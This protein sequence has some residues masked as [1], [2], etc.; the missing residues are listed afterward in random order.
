MK[1]KTTV[2]AC[3]LWTLFAA[4]HLAGAGVWQNIN[5]GDWSDPANWTG[6]VPNGPGDV[7]TFGQAYP[8]RS[9]WITFDGEVRVGTIESLN[10]NVLSLGG[11]GSL[12]MDAADNGQ[13]ELRLHPDAN[14]IRIYN[15][16]AVA[17]GDDLLAD[18][19][20]GAALQLS[21][22]FDGG[23]AAV[24]K[25]GPGRLILTESASTWTGPLDV[26]GGTVEVYDA[27]SL[28]S[29]T[30]ATR[31]AAGG[32][33]AIARNVG[34]GAEPIVLD[35]GTLAGPA[36]G[37]ATLTGPVELR[38]TG[39]LRSEGNGRLRVN[40]PIHG[41][42]ELTVAGNRV[43]FNAANTYTGDVRVTGGELLV[44]HAEALGNPGG[45]TTIEADGTLRLGV[46]DIPDEPIVLAGG[47]LEGPTGGTATFGGTLSGTGTS[48][49]G[50]G[51]IRL[52]GEN[53]FSGTM[54]LTSGA[55]LIAD[56]ES[57]LGPA[58]ANM[59]IHS[60]AELLVSGGLEFRGG[61][62][63]LSGG[64]MEQAPGDTHGVTVYNAIELA[65][66]TRSRFRCD[67]N[68]RFYLRGP[69]TGSGDVSFAGSRQWGDSFSLHGENTYTGK[70]YLDAESTVVNVYHPSGLGSPKTGTVVEAG[71]L[72]FEVSSSEP[73]EVLSGGAL[74]L[75]P[76]DESYLGTCLLRGGSLVG[77]YD[78]S[79]RRTVLES[80]LIIDRGTVGGSSY[81]PLM[82]LKNG[83]TGKRTL[84]TRR[85]TDAIIEGTVDHFGDFRASGEVELTGRV[86]H[87][88][89]L[90]VGDPYEQFRKGKVTLAAGAAQ[91][92]GTTF[93]RT[94]GLVFE[95]DN[96]I[97]TLVLDGR[98]DY[99]LWTPSTSVRLGS[100]L[101]IEGEFRFFSGGFSGNLDGV[102]EI[103]KTTRAYGGLSHLGEGFDGPIIVYGGQLG[104]GDE[105]GLGSSVGTTTVAASENAALCIGYYARVIEDVYLNNATGIE[106]EG[107]LYGRYDPW[108]MGELG[109]N[110]FL[111]DRG[112]CIGGNLVLSAAIHGGALTKVDNSE[113][114]IT[115]GA[116]TYTGPTTVNQ[117]ELILSGQGRLASTAGIDVR[118]GSRL[119]LDNTGEGQLPDRVADHLPVSLNSGT[120]RLIG[121]DGQA[122]SETLGSVAV[123]TGM[124]SLVAVSGAE[125][126]SSAALTVNSLTRQPGCVVKFE[127][128]GNG[129]QIHLPAAELDNNLM[130]GWAMCVADTRTADFATIGA[131]GV[132]PY[133]D[134]HD[135][136]TD[137]DAAGP[138]DNVR[139][140]ADATLNGDVTVNA[141]L[142]SFVQNGRTLDLGGATLNLGSGGLLSGG[143]L[144][145][146]NGHLTA[147]GNTPGEL[148][149]SNGDFTVVADIVDNFGPVD[150]TVSGNWNK[151]LLRG[152]NT[153]SG[154]TTVNGS[155]VRVESRE[156]L[157]QGTPLEINGGTLSIDFSDEAPVHLGQITVRRGGRVQGQASS[158]IDADAYLIEN[159]EIERLAGT[160]PLVKTTVGK[161][162]IRDA[163]QYLGPIT[164]EQGMLRVE[165][166]LPAP[167]RPGEGTITVRQGG[168]FGAVSSSVGRNLVLD[169]GT[170]YAWNGFNM[171]IEVTRRGTISKV[172]ADKDSAGRGK[173]T[174]EADLVL[175]GEFYQSNWNEESRF[176]NDL[177][178]FM[179][180]LYAA[181]GHVALLNDNRHYRGDVFVTAYRLVAR[182][183]YALGAGTTYVL[184]EGTLAAQTTVDASIE[185]AGGTLHPMRKR[186]VLVRPLPVTKSSRLDIMK[187]AAKIDL[188]GGALLADGVRL[189]KHGEGD[190]SIRS[191]LLL[192]GDNSM[193]AFDGHVR[194][195]GTIVADGPNCRLDMIGQDTFVLDASIRVPA[196]NELALA[197]NGTDAILDI[198]G[199][200][201]S[202]AGGGTLLNDLIVGGGA[203]LRPGESAGTLTVDGDLTLG[204][205]AAY[206]WEIRDAAGSAG[207]YVGWDLLHVMG[208]LNLAAESSS[209][210]ELRLVGLAYDGTPGA[211]DRFDPM[212]NYQ[213]TVASADAI[214]GFDPVAF[215]VDAA[216]F[217]DHNP[218]A[219]LGGF[220]VHQ[221]GG[222]LVLAYT[223]PEPGTWAL[224]AAGAA[225]LFGAGLLRRR[226]R[227]GRDG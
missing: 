216:D 211:V 24:T 87:A 113:L 153:Y 50:R 218:V 176:Y 3:L 84:T 206:E 152:E 46:V 136:V 36:T 40:G 21:G 185:L 140:D 71:S 178:D 58:G 80:K 29:T 158:P 207:D 68:D 133:S 166:S 174:G 157:P 146:T 142:V 104:V 39:T 43:E 112:S 147:G 150:L 118:G 131:E 109:G 88:G 111:G 81:S 94:E 184:P 93:V 6:G 209:P 102:E 155:R 110:L 78:S 62:I 189:T 223:V 97:S 89:D 30:G 160:G 63:T 27:G 123:E 86:A 120:V 51:T 38:S 135:Y 5:T 74:I 149:L 25:T 4:G 170:F 182:H 114:V 122:S 37:T 99:R 180:D 44:N 77:Q 45:S 141:M 83:I 204:A 66:S 10:E 55:R 90:V 222:D 143:A 75:P 198:R 173:I 34:L 69:I 213:W 33:L 20:A 82:T 144:T 41:A 212:R 47:M 181:G 132:V 139:L 73:V 226:R 105:T 137:L 169:G 210:C 126:G 49:I 164:V 59:V 156:A 161:G 177:N 199:S 8:L 108:D 61:K 165:G 127:T 64:T 100:R 103:V 201:K 175:D 107:A 171:P 179:G 98:S 115:G 183:K 196:D 18:V 129:A 208:T 11:T 7:A 200:G 220:S 168:I 79:H 9:G 67:T 54:H 60:G 31:L 116:H 106:H 148:M 15:D 203:V 28:G 191:D 215:D 125:P 19:A 91:Y 95:G 221:Q 23:T 1:T 65:E 124:S 187:S 22:L 117:G 151:V 188:S 92:G 70:T 52:T 13:A 219:P 2:L 48:T 154:K 197:F 26:L 121:T 195:L 72:V 162:T 163:S 214:V 56:N 202:V 205:L 76:P 145:L 119:M 167:A 130:G 172:P 85:F 96:T 16:L 53:H 17:P 225:A 224:L 217:L 227:P 134:L 186:M 101:T 190:L 42:G 159:G 138:N 57:A 194:I 192:G 193:V 35:G 32:T 14:M 128:S 12:V